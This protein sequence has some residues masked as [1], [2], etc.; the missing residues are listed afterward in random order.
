MRQSPFE[1]VSR[2]RKNKVTLIV[3]FRVILF[4]PVTEENTLKEPDNELGTE[5]TYMLITILKF[6]V[7]IRLLRS[8]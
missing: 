8:Q 4:N 5:A 1:I 2:L 3:T 7:K 6:Y